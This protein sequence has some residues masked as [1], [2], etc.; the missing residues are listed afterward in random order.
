MDGERKEDQDWD[1]C[2]ER[3]YERQGLDWRIKAREMET[4]DR[5]NDARK[6]VGKRMM[7]K[8]TEIYEQLHHH[9]HPHP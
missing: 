7:K 6:V 5:G 1:E 3:D 9:H 4:V 8:K 2:E